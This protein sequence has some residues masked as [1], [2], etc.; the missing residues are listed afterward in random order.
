MRHGFHRHRC[1]IRPLGRWKVDTK[2]LYL[3]VRK[4][5]GEDLRRVLLELELLAT[6]LKIGSSGKDLLM[7]LVRQPNDRESHELKRLSGVLQTGETTFQPRT[8]TRTLLDILGEELPPHVLAGIPKSLDIVGHVAIVEMTPQLESYGTV[9]GQA[10][11]NVNK[12]VR[13]VLAKASQIGTQYRIREF[14]VLAGED[15][16]ETIHKEHGCRYLLDVRKVY[17]SARLGFEHDRVAKLVH[18]GETVIDM[19]AGVGPFSI[20]MAKKR[21]SITV[22]AIDVNPEAI[23][24]LE[25]NVRLNK[26]E[27]KVMPLLGDCRRVVQQKLRGISDRV[28]MNLPGQSFDYLD[29]ACDAIKPTGGAIHLYT[30]SSEAP[31]FE[32]LQKSL[33]ESVESR[34]RSFK[35]ISG[36]RIVKEVAPYRLQ[37]AVDAIVV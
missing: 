20:P 11:L 6:D 35:T 15:H 1:S 9:I 37:V 4:E 3:R 24:Y 25:K 22:Y 28:V 7:P 34:G 36:I 17:F 21:Q 19:F 33:K 14:E 16:T 12:N 5:N 18:D 8:R 26:V 23:K 27:G 13:T 32:A 31:P 10:I 30:F 29:V 2:S